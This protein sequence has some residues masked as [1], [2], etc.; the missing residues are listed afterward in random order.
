MQNTANVTGKYINREDIE[1]G[2]QYKINDFMLKPTGL[3]I[4]DEQRP[5]GERWLCDPLFIS[6]T[7]QNLD[8]KDVHLGLTY[9]YKGSY[10]N[11]EIGMGQ[12]SPNELQ[13]LMAKGVDLPH[14]A[15][16]LIATFL[17]KQQKFAPHREKYH[18]VGWHK[19]EGDKGELVFR[20]HHMIGQG[21]VL[22]PE[23]DS[24]NG[25]YE[26][27][28]KGEL[29]TWCEMVRTHVRG[30]APLEA[31]LATG[32]ASAIVGYLARRY[33]D[34]DT[35][36]THL[37]GNSTQGK[38]TAALLAV[39]PFGMPSQR[40]K[41]LGKTWNG[42]TNALLN[43][44][45]GN[46]GIPIVLDELSM[47][48]TESL[49]DVLY[50]LA[51]GQEKSRL[52]DTIQQ[53]K[54]GTWALGIISTGEQSIFARTNRNIG[55]TVRIFELSQVQWTLSAHHADAIRGV[56]QDH[57]GH[58]GQ[59]FI[60]NI[61]QVG[62]ERIDET[63]KRWQETCKDALVDTPF[64]DRVAKKYAIILTAAEL[65]NEALDIDLSTE[66]IL[67]FLKEQEETAND[68]RDIGLKAWR[69]IIE[70]VIEHQNHFKVE[71]R[72]HDNQKTWGKIFDREDHFEVAIL[73]SVLERHLK[74]LG[75][76]EPKVVLKEWR[77][78]RW[79]LTEGD[80]P[81]KRTRIFEADETSERK[82]ALGQS[83]VPRKLEDTTYNL[84]VERQ[85]LEELM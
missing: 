9:L 83:R 23:N 84:R 79:L 56:I 8:T 31:I 44:L 41:G 40:K 13:K 6:E 42:T 16:R 50:V 70:R 54:Q 27:A 73:K 30:H 45:G 11:I 80:R 34:V 26:L 77:A 60:E 75:Y 53:R 63:W 49:T 78:R 64:R 21:G 68:Q 69:Q 66:R 22:R 4:K 55:L 1:H 25:N 18:L 71:G 19:H 51:S 39:S 3:Y 46:Y 81:T 24:E 43:M 47:N 59:T 33:D 17:R 2:Q 12:I 82:A 57:Y 74:E 35:F 29:R 37:A 32:F 72:R 76:D 14:E 7:V 38:T 52:T 85:E 28:P 36:V 48:N 10:Q 15:V 5:T 58:A 62:H 61:L 65:A 67:G 20:H